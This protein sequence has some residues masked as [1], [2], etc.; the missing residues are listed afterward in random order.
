M[1]YGCQYFLS[2]VSL[3]MELFL[4]VGDFS[5]SENRM[6]EDD[7]LIYPLPIERLTTNVS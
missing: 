3:K 1:L 6:S 5:D 4:E 7:I 2:I